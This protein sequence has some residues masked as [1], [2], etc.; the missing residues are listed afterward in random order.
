[1][2]RSRRPVGLE[3]EEAETIRRELDEVLVPIARKHCLTVRTLLKLAS[4][5]GSAQA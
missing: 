1:M 5:G 4:V 2:K 3:F